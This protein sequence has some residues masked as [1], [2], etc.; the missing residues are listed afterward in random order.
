MSSID[1][2]VLLVD[3]LI[4]VDASTVLFK[5]NNTDSVVVDSVVIDGVVVGD[6]YVGV[7]VDVGVVVVDDDVGV[8][9]VDDDVVVVIAVVVVTTGNILSMTEI[10]LQVGQEEMTLLKTS[11]LVNATS[12]ILSLLKSLIVIPDG[13]PSYIN[14]GLE[15]I[16]V[17]F[18]R[19]TSH[20]CIAQYIISMQPSLLKSAVLTKF[21]F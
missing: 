15:N 13:H 21:G 4:L 17:Q 2:C 7:V 1:N 5:Y 11:E 14:I 20:D 10:L 16:P 6:D 19:S 12:G 8:V 18:P 9:V 3:E